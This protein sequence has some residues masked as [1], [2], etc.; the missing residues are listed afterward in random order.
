MRKKVLSAGQLSRTTFPWKNYLSVKVVKAKNQNS[1]GRRAR[2]ARGSTRP[3]P[4]PCCHSTFDFT[5]SS[6]SIEKSV[7]QT[8]ILES[9]P[10]K[11]A[12]YNHYS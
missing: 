11:T 6:S 1:Q 10:I 5:A 12:Q 2:H 4:L 9:L 7:N 8:H 3:P